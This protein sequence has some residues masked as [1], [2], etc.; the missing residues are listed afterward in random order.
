VTQYIESRTYRHSGCKG[1][2]SAPPVFEELSA[3]IWWKGIANEANSI[4]YVR[5]SC[6][7]AVVVGIR[8]VQDRDYTDRKNGREMARKGNR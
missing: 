6:V 2:S 8:D 3:V 7:G 4:Y 5:E 1:I